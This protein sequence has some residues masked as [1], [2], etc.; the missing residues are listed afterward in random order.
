MQLIHPAARDYLV[1]QYMLPR[2]VFFCAS[3]V[4]QNTDYNWSR[5]DYNGALFAGYMTF[6]GRGQLD[7]P[8]RQ[9]VTSQYAGWE[10]VTRASPGPIPVFPAKLGQ[11]AF[12]DVLVA[13]MTRSYG[14]SLFE[15]NHVFGTDATGYISPLGT[16]GANVGYSDGHVEWKAQSEIG[17]A[18]TATTPSGRREFYYVPQTVRYYF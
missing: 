11:K 12:Y 3:Q 18:P 7:V 15:S 1:K 4:E 9:I 8:F 17:Q 13:D 16:G 2:N 6:A 14:N 5:P 10:E